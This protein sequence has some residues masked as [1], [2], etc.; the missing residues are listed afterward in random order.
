[1]YILFLKFHLLIVILALIHELSSYSLL[2][3]SNLTFGEGNGN[4]F[5]YSC[6][7]NFT[8]GYYSSRGHKELDVTEHNLTFKNGDMYLKY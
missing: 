1:M 3:T 8:E 4:S 7:E 5:Q 6:L 2:C